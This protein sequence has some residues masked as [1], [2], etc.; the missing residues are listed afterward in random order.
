MEGF[1]ADKSGDQDVGKDRTLISNWRDS[2]DAQLFSATPHFDL[3]SGIYT[4]PSNGLYMVQVNARLDGAN[5][6][7]WV[8]VAA[9]IDGA[10]TDGM[11]E[12]V[13]YDSSDN[14]HSFTGSAVYLLRRGQTVSVMTE[15]NTDTF[16]RLQSE[17]GFAVM[18]LSDA[19]RR[20]SCTADKWGSQAA[21]AGPDRPVG[22]WAARSNIARL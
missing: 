11:L 14:Y 7:D 22:S 10:I 16:F 9:S 20:P 8:R 12:L 15:A 13:D 18:R 4:A 2:G 17:S 5:T 19:I 21:P 1:H 6:Q 3:R